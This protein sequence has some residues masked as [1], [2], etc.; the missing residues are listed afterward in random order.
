ML[1]R[2][3]SDTPQPALEQR[4]PVMVGRIALGVALGILTVLLAIGAL[5]ALNGRSDADHKLDRACADLQA[6]QR[7]TGDTVSNCG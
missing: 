2:M 6:Q 4:S 5:N 3:V 1:A 7:A